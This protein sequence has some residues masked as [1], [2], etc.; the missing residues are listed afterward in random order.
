MSPTAEL[1]APVA[2]PLALA[3]A[4]AWVLSWL[5]PAKPQRPHL[6]RTALAVGVPWITGHLMINGLNFFFP[7]AAGVDWLIFTTAGWTL[8]SGLAAVHSPSVLWRRAPEGPQRARIIQ[9]VV[10]SPATLRRST[11]DASSRKEVEPRRG[12]PSAF[13]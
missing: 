6:F 4:L 5:I 2:V 9:R 12:G 10:T 7:P 3:A 13:K 1:F 8:V 11:A